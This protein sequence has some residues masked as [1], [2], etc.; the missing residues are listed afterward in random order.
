MLAHRS[1]FD[2]FIIEEG[3]FNDYIERK[4]IVGLEW[5]DQLELIAASQ[6][7]QFNFVVYS[8]ESLNIRYQHHYTS[9]FPTIYL[10]FYGNNHY[11]VLFPKQTKI[12]VKLKKED[13]NDMKESSYSKRRIKNNER[14]FK[15]NT[16]K[17][18]EAIQKS[19]T[20][21]QKEK[22]STTETHN[23]EI[24]FSR[25]G[26]QSLYMNAKGSHNT[27]NEAYGYLKYN[28]IPERIKLLKSQKFWKKE[29]ENKYF[30]A[31]VPQSKISQSLLLYKSKKNQ[32]L[33]IPFKSEVITIIANAHNN[34]STIRIRH[35]G[36]HTTLHNIQA[37]FIYWAGMKQD[38]ED[39]IALCPECIQIKPEKAIKTS[40]IIETIKPLYRFVIDLYQIPVKF[41]EAAALNGHAKFRYVLMC[42]DHFSKYLW[43]VLIENKEGETILKELELIFNQFGQP[44]LL[45]SDNGKEFK[46]HKLKKFC[47]DRKIKIKTGKP[48]HPKSQGAIERLNCFLGESFTL[49]FSE[50]QERNENGKRFELEKVLKAYVNSH[51]NNVHTVTGYKPNI[52]ILDND[53][54][55]IAE[56]NK[57]IKI[58]YEKKNS[59][60]S[61]RSLKVGMKVYIIGDVMVSKKN[62]LIPTKQ[63]V[64]K[65][66]IKKK[67]EKKNHIKIAASIKDI[68]QIQ[69]NKVQVVIHGGKLLEEMKL[70]ETYNIETNYLA[71]AKEKQWMRLVN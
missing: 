25:Q 53:E 6:I 18:L 2:G 23:P 37:E 19:N 56:V 32:T 47:D 57:K 14:T 21:I 30:I 43:G 63:A 10:E 62:N 12:N 4:R 22:S 31:K 70:E 17:I 36:I 41:T 33:T 27:Y 34:Y 46:N 65:N 58:Y 49:A 50:F 71:I 48:F 11:D 29:I 40:Q 69:A 59:R 20:S 35:N 26:L 60:I 67:G 5:G 51:N 28:K 45:H 13:N 9:I 52:L 68:S 3:T 42:V 24:K 38:I 8:S 7:L 39:Y 44:E 61:Q 54:L 1:D 66:I 16:K 64:K 55:K 15:Y